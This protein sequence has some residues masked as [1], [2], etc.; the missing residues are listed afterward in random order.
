MEN[1]SPAK[2]EYAYISEKQISENVSSY[3]REK[4]I[5]AQRVVFSTLSFTIPHKIGE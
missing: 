4:V 3:I 2:L 5:L 1:L